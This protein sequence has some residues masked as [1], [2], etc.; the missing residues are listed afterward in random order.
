V[1]LI[2]DYQ[3]GIIGLALMTWE[4]IYGHMGCMGMIWYSGVFEEI[5]NRVAKCN[6]ESIQNKNV[7]ES[8]TAELE[9]Y[10]ER[11]RMFEER[12]KVNLND[13]EKYSESQMND[14]STSGFVQNPPSTTPYVPPTKN[15][16][17]LLFQPMFDEY[18]NPPSR[19]VS[20]VYVAAA[21]RP[22][23]PTSLPSSTSI[24]QATPSATKG[25]RQ[26]ERIDFEESFT[27]VARIEAIRIFVANAANKNMTIYQMDVK[28]AFLNS[29]L[30][31]VVY[32]SQPEGFV[33]PDNPTC[34]Y[35]P[36]KA[37]LWLKAGSTI[38]NPQE[39]QQVARDETLVLTVERVK[40][41]S[42]NMRIDPTM[43][44]KEETFQVVLDLIKA[45]PC[46]NAFL[47]T[48]DVPEIYMQQFWFTV[49][50]IKRTTSYEFNLTDKMFQVDVELFR[51][52]LGICPTKRRIRCT[53]I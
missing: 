35:R 37:L 21:Q 40:I 26:E 23:E 18:F 44:Q 51:K 49:K 33:D 36:K 4:G 31:E 39:I 25:Y 27:P 28:T 48:A 29:E 38:M 22:A 16:W 15:D 10:K 2:K 3:L 1:R 43:T 9:R 42:T 13:R 14:I 12:K 7:N 11:V 5:T 50:K 30:C 47:I 53:S 41:S 19:V 24:D 8:L 34:V 32:V 52:V 45:S 20:P 6:A 46:Y 17:D